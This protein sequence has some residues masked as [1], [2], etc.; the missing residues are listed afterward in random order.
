L[1]KPKKKDV[2]WGI[3]KTPK[4]QELYRGNGKEETFFFLIRGKIRGENQMIES[5]QKAQAPMQQTSE[6]TTPKTQ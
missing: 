1:G 6:K 3:S 5:A 4:R 2:M